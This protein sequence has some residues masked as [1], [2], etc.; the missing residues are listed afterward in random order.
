M[1]LCAPRPSQIRVRLGVECWHTLAA[2]RGLLSNPVA[3]CPHPQT[4]NCELSRESNRTQGCQ[5]PSMRCCSFSMETLTLFPPKHRWGLEAYPADPG[6][7]CNIP[8]GAAGCP[9][10]PCGLCS[11]SH[12]GDV[13]V[14]PAATT[15]LAWHP[16]V[17]FPWKAK[18]RQAWRLAINTPQCQRLWTARSPHVQG[19]IC[20]IAHHFEDESKLLFTF[21]DRK[22]FFKAAGGRW[23]ACQSAPAP[24]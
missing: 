20:S 13:F 23:A 7:G 4:S 18:P 11:G 5:R 6:Q 19:C 22:L 24:S 15:L 3:S 8:L 14:I 9:Q 12:S 10:D 16:V 2:K 17:A 1:P 21:I